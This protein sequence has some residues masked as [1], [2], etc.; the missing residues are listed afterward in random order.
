MSRTHQ[1]R[2]SRGLPPELDPVSVSAMERETEPMF[3]ASTKCDPSNP[4]V[5]GAA[6]EGRRR[7]NAR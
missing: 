2:M 6:E 7:A 1:S 3:E 4:E 5:G